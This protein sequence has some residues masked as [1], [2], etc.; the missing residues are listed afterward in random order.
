MKVALVGHGSI[1]TRYKKKLVTS[2][3]PE[4][5]LY[6]VDTNE[7][8][9]ED[10]IKE[11]FN[12]FPSL[13]ELSNKNIQITHGIIANWGP[14]H[15]KT[16]HSLI[17][18]G[19]KRLIIEKPLSS[20]KDAINSLKQRCKEENIFVTIHHHWNYTNILN[21][22]RESQEKF[23]LGNNVGIRFM[24]GAVCLSTNGT[25]Y[26]DLGCSLLNS[27]PREITADL[28]L[29]YIN[30]RSKDLVN[31]GGM[32]SYRMENGTFI[33]ASFSNSNSQAFKSE[34]IY[35]HGIIKIN[36]NLELS[37]YKRKEDEILMYGEKIT[38]YGDMDFLSKI[39]FKDLNTIDLI[40][41][42]LFYDKEPVVSIE[43][44]EVAILMVIGAIDSHLSNKKIRFDNIKDNGILIS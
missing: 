37:C 13:L 5:E 25:H 22:I 19:C 44:A 6:I 12:A 36:T 34:I 4:D 26:F 43:Q 2:L 11:G 27:I 33:H 35:R 14:E 16:A 18:L 8:I 10:L 1:G 28:E 15:I 17:D 31:I 24:G 21:I 38:R 29:D 7:Y 32:A 23:A 42:N 20:R 40:L 3:M 30:P 39:N 41:K 9:V